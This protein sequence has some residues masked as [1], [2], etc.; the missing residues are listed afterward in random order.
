MEF[1]D[2]SKARSFLRVRVMVD[3]KKLLTTGCWLPQK[4]NKDTWVEFRYERLQDCYYSYGRIGHTNTDCSFDQSSG[5]ATR[6]GEWTKIGRI[7]E[8]MDLPTALSVRVGER[9][10]VGTVRYGNNHALQGDEELLR[11]EMSA[12]PEPTHIKPQRGRTSRGT[13][14]GR[15]QRVRQVRND[16]MKRS[17][18]AQRFLIAGMPQTQNHEIGGMQL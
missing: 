10:V 9:K 7:R 5:E 3:T 14:Q 16:V 2:P 15:L 1:E 12:D 18:S 8:M 11:N 13:S 4:G 6:Y 17:S